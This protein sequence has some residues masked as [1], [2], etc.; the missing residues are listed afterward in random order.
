MIS[1]GPNA[2]SQA[3]QNVPWLELDANNN[4]TAL[5]YFNGARWINI[6]PSNAITSPS[7]NMKQVFGQRSITIKKDSA[8]KTMTSPAINFGEIFSSSVTPLIMITPVYSDLQVQLD[9]NANLKFNYYVT[10]VTRTDF[11]I[12]YSYSQPKLV[13]DVAI[14][15]GTNAVQGEDLDTLEAT[16][17]LTTAQTFKFNFTALGQI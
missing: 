6:A 11:K 7:T 5:K 10:D 9:T 3:Y 12:S 16:P 1:V 2:P 13:T 4:P 17:L 14:P 15:D 8:N